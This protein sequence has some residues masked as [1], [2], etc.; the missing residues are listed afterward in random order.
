M[1]KKLEFDD[2]LAT[3]MMA[4]VTIIDRTTKYFDLP[5]LLE[6][7]LELHSQQDSQLRL[8]A[9]ISQVVTDPSLLIS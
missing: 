8:R 3:L 7:F 4:N 2:V 1:K 5:A 9:D 6:I